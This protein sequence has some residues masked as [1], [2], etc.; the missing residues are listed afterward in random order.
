MGVVL[1]TFATVILLIADL[2][3]VTEGRLKWAAN[4]RPSKK[5]QVNAASNPKTDLPDKSDGVTP[6][7]QDGGP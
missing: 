5:M 3:R 4:V 7:A 1:A 2:D 6:D